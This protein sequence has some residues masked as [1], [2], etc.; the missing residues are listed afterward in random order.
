MAEV[1]VHEASLEIQCSVAAFCPAWA[2]A[3]RSTLEGYKVG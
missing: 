1:V 2:P 3:T